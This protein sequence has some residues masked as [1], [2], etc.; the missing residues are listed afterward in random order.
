MHST[1]VTVGVDLDENEVSIAKQRNQPKMGDYLERRATPFE[2]QLYCGD[3]TQFDSRVSGCDCVTLVEVIEHL[4]DNELEAL[5]LN[6]FGRINSKHVVVTTPNSEFNVVF[7]N[8]SGFRHDD[9]KFE[10]TRD[11]FQAWYFSNSIISCTIFMS[12]TSMFEYYLK[13]PSF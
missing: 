2:V 10:W 12:V 11:E 4:K 13:C 1:R 6:V 7:P 5:P 3:V 9:H 8:F